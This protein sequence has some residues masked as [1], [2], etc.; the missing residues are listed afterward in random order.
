MIKRKNYYEILGVTPNS[1]DAEIKSVYRK[2]A[3]KYHP[4]VNP[5][6]SELFKEITE[7]Y[8]TLSR[9]EKRKQYDILNG[10]F[11]TEETKTSSKKAEEEYRSKA[12]EQDDKQPKTGVPHQKPK[13]DFSKKINEI[14]EEFKKN[15]TASNPQ[16]KKEKAQP[17]KGEDIYT[18][19]SITISESL[20]GTTRTV[21]VMHSEQ[22]PLCRGR[23]FINGTKCSVCSGKGEVSNHRKITVK[24]PKDIK[25]TAKLRIPEEGNAGKNGGKNGDLYLKVKIE[26]TSKIKY[27]GLNILYN[28]PITPFEAVLGG[29]ITVPTFEGNISLKV[30]ANTNSGQKFRLAGQGLVENG[31]IGDM[32]VTVHIEIPCSLSDDERK[33]YEKLRK[34][35]QHNLRENLLNE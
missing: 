8:D 26:G 9:V 29:D 1:S 21:N 23:K 3:R 6:S 11:K 17:V 30:P 14:F 18:D 19:I 33:L 35:S 13:E 20:K 5:N 16:K 31:K 28:L 10:F 2:L 22:C 25:N 15:S 12:F 34:M 32:I 24:I 27:D 4:D 7:A